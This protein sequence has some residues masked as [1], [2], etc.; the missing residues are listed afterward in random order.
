MKRLILASF[1]AIALL[2]SCKSNKELTN[3]TTVAA[4]TPAAEETATF[5]ITEPAAPA[6]SSSATTAATSATTTSTYTPSSDTSTS[7]YT[8]STNVR[9]QS[10]E[11]AFD[12]ANDAGLNSGNSYFVIVGSFSSLANANRYKAELS[13][14]GFSAIVLH[15][16]TGYYRV[17][18]NSY[19]SEESARVRISQIR[20]EF[21]EHA[22]CWLLVKK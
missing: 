21:P 5:E 15:S 2:A 20:S 12:S 18:V 10:E 13:P 14:K 4:E 1:A 7:T 3:A 8:P 9:K 16:D 17:C 11:F 19:S 22:D 6:T